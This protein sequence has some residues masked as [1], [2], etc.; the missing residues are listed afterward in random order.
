MCIPN[1]RTLILSVCGSGNRHHG[2]LFEAKYSEKEK[3]RKKT[4]ENMPPTTYCLKAERGGD[5]VEF[6]GS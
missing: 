6:C 3:N 5:A 4:T 1:T 2:R